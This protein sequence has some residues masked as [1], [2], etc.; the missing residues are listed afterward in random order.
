MLVPSDRSDPV[1]RLIGPHGTRWGTPR[2]SSCVRSPIP[3]RS[4]AAVFNCSPA[5]PWTGRSTPVE[6]AKHRRIATFDGYCGDSG[7]SAQ[8][9]SRDFV[10]EH[11]P[12]SDA[13][14]SPKVLLVNAVSGVSARGRVTRGIACQL[15]HRRR[16]PRC[17]SVVGAVRSKRGEGH[18]DAVHAV[19]QA[20][21]LRSVVE[22][23]AEVASAPVAENFGACHGQAGVGPL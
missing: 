21:R 9:A 12:A 7:E 17:H 13:A 6:V 14:C 1:L 2:S 5:I 16:I 20:G 15:R 11:L 3:V 22:Y 19:P 10:V 18:G 23:V 8:H 4:R